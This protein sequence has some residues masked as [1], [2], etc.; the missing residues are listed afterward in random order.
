MFFASEVR[1]WDVFEV[2]VN[3]PSNGNPFTDQH[4]SGVFRSDNE[5]KEI[6]GFY[7]GEGI[8]KVR[9]MPS[10]TGKYSFSIRASFFDGEQSGTVNVI[11]NDPNNHGVVRVSNKFH[12]SYDDGTRFIPSGT[13]CYVWELQNKELQEETLKSLE[14][15]PFNKIRFCVFPKHY[16]YNF[17][18]PISFPYEGKP[19]DCTKLTLDNF[20]SFEGRPEGNDWDYKRF[21]P[22]HFQ[23]IENCIKKLGDM[24][25]EADLIIMHPYDRWGFSM[26]SEEEDDLY[27]HYVIARFASYH[28]VW[29]SL[30]NEYDLMTSKT[31]KDWERYA[32]IICKMD[33]YQHLRSIHNCK[34]FYNYSKPWVTHCSIQKTDHYRSTENTDFWSTMYQKPVILDEIS[35]EG[36]IQHKW[37]NIS[38]QELVRRY[39]EAAC[40]GGYAQHGETYLSSDGVL[41]WSHGGKLKGDSP[42][43]IR[44]LNKILADGPVDGLAP[45]DG[46]RD[47]VCGIE[48]NRQRENSRSMPSYYLIYYGYFRPSFKDYYFDDVNEYKVDIIDTWEMT[49]KELGVFRGKIHVD[50]PGKEYMALRIQKVK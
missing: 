1:K 19:M 5:E 16:V 29:W 6:E 30:A 40:R 34:A 50:L 48:D 47:D 31:E 45:Y 18:D 9:F 23:H 37:G 22:K 44:F 28:N 27:W 32:S 41:W 14:K 8:Y 13:T 3:G 26:M 17:H 42:E 4:I 15:S 20:K 43:R 12:M 33:K 49:I 11:A 36:N 38:G 46:I 21:N 7:D 24:G 35:Y 25:I 2:S 10:F 39:W